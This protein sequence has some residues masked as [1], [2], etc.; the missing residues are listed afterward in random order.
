MDH[1]AL[2]LQLTLVTPWGNVRFQLYFVILPGPD[3]L[4]TQGPTTLRE[5]LGVV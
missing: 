3:N 1:Q 4:V 2:S 5:V